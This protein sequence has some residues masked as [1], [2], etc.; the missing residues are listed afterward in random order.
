[1]NSESK[2]S[3]DMLE[4][5]INEFNYQEC[6]DLQNTLNNINKYFKLLLS[7]SEEGTDYTEIHI[8]DQIEISRKLNITYTISNIVLATIP[9]SA[10][11][12]PEMKLSLD[13]ADIKEVFDIKGSGYQKKLTYEDWTEIYSIITNIINDHID[14]LK[15]LGEA[16]IKK[17]AITAAK[18]KSFNLGSLFKSK[19]KKDYDDDDDFYDDDDDFYDDDEY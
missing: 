4:V 15:K 6:L 3:R 19:K 10:S 2:S 7:I 12:D 18:K 11:I 17:P 8:S 13:P 16:K 5:V 9:K 1:M 14:V